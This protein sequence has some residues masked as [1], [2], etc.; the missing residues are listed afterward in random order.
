M[1]KYS[2]II[3]KLNM[4]SY[5]ESIFLTESEKTKFKESLIDIPNAALILDKIDGIYD[6]LVENSIQRKIHSR[7]DSIQMVLTQLHRLF[8]TPLQ[9]VFLFS[10]F[11]LSIYSTFYHPFDCTS[12]FA[13]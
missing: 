1:K 11:L 9:Y 8:L 10:S 4:S 3:K 5:R 12:Y 6:E 2:L 7:H 13:K